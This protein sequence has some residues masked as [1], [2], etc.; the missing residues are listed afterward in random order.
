MNLQNYSEA[1]ITA[2]LQFHNNH[3]KIGTTRRRKDVFVQAMF[4]S[5]QHENIRES[6]QHKEY[7]DDLMTIYDLLCAVE[8]EEIRQF[9]T[10]E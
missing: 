6:L 2:I 5:F 9:G 1:D 4:A 10:S 8:N 7:V 3:C